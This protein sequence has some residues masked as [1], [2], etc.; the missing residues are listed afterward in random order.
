M[1]FLYQSYERREA[2]YRVASLGDRIDDIIGLYI[3]VSDYL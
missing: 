2:A 1:I 3:K